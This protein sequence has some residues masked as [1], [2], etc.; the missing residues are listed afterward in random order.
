MPAGRH[1][2]SRPEQRRKQLLTEPPSRK[3]RRILTGFVCILLLF[4]S[5]FVTKISRY[6]PEERAGTELIGVI[7]V[8]STHSDGGGSFAAIA[9]K[10]SLAGLDFVVMT[11]HGSPTRPEEKPPDSPLFIIGSEVSTDAGHM[12]AIGNT[13]PAYEFSP[14]PDQAVEDIASEGGFSVIAHPFHMKTPWEQWPL[15]PADGMEVINADSDWRGASWM[16]IATSLPLYWLNPVYF[17]LKFLHYPTESIR[18]FDHEAAQRH[19]LLFAGL[20]AHARIELSQQMVLHIPDYLPLFKTLRIRIPGKVPKTREAIIA[21]LRHGSFYISIDGIASGTGF[22]FKALD[23][24]VSYA[25]G[26]VVPRGPVR[27]EALTEAGCRIRIMRNGIEVASGD[28]RVSFVT[29]DSG[30]YRAEVYRPKRSHPFD[31][32]VPWILSNPIFVGAQ[33]ADQPPLSKA[34]GLA[35]EKLLFESRRFHA[36]ADYLSRANYDG[37]HL[38]FRIGQSRDP[39]AWPVVALCLRTPLQL[40]T[41]DSFVIR[42]HSDRIYRIWLQVHQGEMIFRA[43]VKSHVEASLQVVK[44]T[45][46]QPVPEMAGRTLDPG[47]ITGIYLV[48]DRRSV[49]AG[50]EGHVWLESV[51]ISPTNGAS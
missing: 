45:D 46:L 4:L 40:A 31:P 10:A 21:A 16:K 22:G 6:S 41:S 19:F 25:M 30:A 15:P 14:V 26:D 20:D 36:E 29:I 38:H 49:A 24:K 42:L 48:F 7:H 51:G 47:K 12:L 2:S 28:G 11:D 50:T 43:S 33:Y 32:N 35:P 1:L 5:A 27:I 13:P 9:G 44:M 34:P 23:G 3:L 37:S 8:H 39:R 18:A 17:H